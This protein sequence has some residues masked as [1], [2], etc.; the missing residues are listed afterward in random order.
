MIGEVAEWPEGGT[1]AKVLCG[2]NLASWFE[3]HLL[4][5]FMHNQ[6]FA[7]IVK[8][9]LYVYFSSCISHQIGKFLSIAS[10]AFLP[11]L[12]ARV[13]VVSEVGATSPLA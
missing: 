6:P 3:S 11:A 13:A 1:P 10:E 12:I 4:R 9:F 5:F 2:G 8:G 7:I